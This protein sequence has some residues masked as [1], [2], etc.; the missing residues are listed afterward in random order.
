MTHFRTCLSAIFLLASTLVFGQKVGIN[1]DTPVFD[2]DVRGTDDTDDGGELQLATPSQTNFLRFF[3]GRLGDHHPFMAFSDDDTLHLVTTLPDWSTYT[4]RMTFLPTGQVGIGVQIPQARLD[5]LGGQWNVGATE[6]D[7]RIGTSTYRIVAGVATDGGGAGISRIYAKG[8]QAKLILGSDNTDVL[9]IDSANHVGIGVQSPQAR[10][11]LLGGQ[12][13][14]GATEGDLRIGT[15]TYRLVTGVSTSGGGAGISRIYA[16][17]GQAKLILGSDNTDIVTIDSANHVGIG[18]ISPV[19]RLDIRDDGVAGSPKI[20]LGLISDVSNRPVLQFSEWDSGVAGSGISLE[21]DGND[22]VNPLHI[23]DPAGLRRFTFTSTGLMGIGVTAPN[24]MLE[25][26]GSGRIFIGDGMGATRKGLL[27]AAVNGGNF[28]RLHPYNYT[29]ASNMDL[30]IPGNVGI[31]TSTPAA[32]L[33]VL[34]AENNGTNAAVKIS[35][36]TGMVTHNLL[37][38]GNEIDAVS[39]YLALQGNTNGNL[40]MV[41]GG[42]NVGIGTVA[43]NA[44]LAVNGAMTIST[45]V[46]ATGYALSVGGKIIAE[47]VRIQLQVD[48]PDYVFDDNF[49]LPRLKEV[50]HYISEN[51]HLPGIPSATEIRTDGLLLGDMQARMMQKIEE[52]TLY[53]IQQQEHIEQLEQEIYSLKAKLH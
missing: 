45:S 40:L 4:R 17:G 36:T 10:L 27:I 24:E 15:S 18:T 2:L 25:V 28:V 3:S 20:V 31:G 34:G 23:R 13:N 53:L 19:N 38:D 39:T 51:D 33:H 7:L 44:K 29:N 16:K 35:N 1:T 26:G 41:T 12:W 47:E 14:V 37:I 52:L 5:L 50:A 48:W 22:A 21:Y 30:Y 8:G 11:D 46:P 42:G 6:G 32:M 49:T 43:P 9:A